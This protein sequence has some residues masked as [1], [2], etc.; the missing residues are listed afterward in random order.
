M[1]GN[2]TTDGVGS[3]GAGS[4]K[5]AT[6]SSGGTSADAS[7]ADMPAG[8]L[9]IGGVGAVAAAGIGGV[10][11]ATRRSGTAIAHPIGHGLAF[12]AELP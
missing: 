11:G 3:V 7:A 6:M 10:G 5:P 12:A 2:G 4:E 8:S 9:G 1:R